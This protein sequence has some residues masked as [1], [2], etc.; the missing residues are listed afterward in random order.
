MFPYNSCDAHSNLKIGFFHRK[1]LD[2]QADF[3]ILILY[4]QDL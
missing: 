1:H 2:Y 3:T 4:A